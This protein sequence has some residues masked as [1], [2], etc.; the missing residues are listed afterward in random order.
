LRIKCPAQNPT[1]RGAMRKMFLA[2]LAVAVA[3]S[4]AAVSFA[5]EVVELKEKTAVREGKVVTKVEAKDLET[6]AKVKA[7]ER[8]T[9]ADTT[10]K[11]EVK[12]KEFDVKTK[13]HITDAEVAGKTKAKIKHGAIKKL[14]LNYEYYQEGPD[15]I[16]EYNIKDKADPDLVALLD[17]TPEQLEALTPGHHKVVSTS[18]Y[19]ADDMKADFQNIILQ[20]IKQA[21]ASKKKK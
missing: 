8:T 17:L 6:G 16:L 10:M 18:P 11:G 5:D 4:F 2:V 21:V 1:R 9:D 15:Y 19:T 14:S 3:V 12:G 20:D 13:K 7:K